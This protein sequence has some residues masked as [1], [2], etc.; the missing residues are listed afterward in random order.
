MLRLFKRKKEEQ[1][2]APCSGILIPLEDVKDDMFSKKLLG[3]GFAIKPS[4]EMICAPCSGRIAMIAK[5]AHAFGII[6]DN[7][8]EFL[9]HVGLD[10]VNLKGQ[11]FQVLKSVDQKVSAGTP[12]LKI[13]LSFIK[14]HDIDFTIPIVLTN[15][16]EFHIDILKKKGEIK[17][18]E[19]ILNIIKS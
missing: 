8:A 3:D 18:Q 17:C 2:K 9:V 13:D 6:A 19:D 4:D 16:N 1:I 12:I 5:T 15:R 7:G 11:G 14:E 10:T